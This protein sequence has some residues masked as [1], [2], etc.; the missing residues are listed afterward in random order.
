[1]GKIVSSQ[2]KEVLQKEHTK[3][4]WGSVGLHLVGD[5][6]PFAEKYSCKTLLDYGSGQGLTKKRIVDRYGDKYN[7]REYEPGIPGKDVL[8]EPADFVICTDVLEH[9][10]PELIGNVLDH[11]KQLTLKAA[12]F[13][14]S[15]VKAKRI[16]NDGRNAHLIVESAEWW[17]HK[18]Q[19][20][21]RIINWYETK[22]AGGY[23]MEP[24]ND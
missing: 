13:Q 2:Y 24:R 4:P 11:L 3:G 18:L 19:K 16:L 5:F 23:Y 21:Y 20:R 9:I 15:T 7:I 1:M 10:E 8:P 14:V 22:Q 12:F 17:Y 6:I